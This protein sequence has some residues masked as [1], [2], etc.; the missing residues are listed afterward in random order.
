M[1]AT[2]ATHGL[3]RNADERQ[4]LP[5]ESGQPAAPAEANAKNPK[6]TA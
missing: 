6:A 4:E 2:A 3:N 5:D 1:V